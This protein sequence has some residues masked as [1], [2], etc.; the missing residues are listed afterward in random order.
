[1]KSLVFS[2]FEISHTDRERKTQVRYPYMPF[3]DME[4][5]IPGM[6]QPRC[7]YGEEGDIL[8]IKEAWRPSRMNH[9]LTDDFDPD[10]GPLSYVPKA[11]AHSQYEYFADVSPKYRHESGVWSS[12]ETMPTEAARFF[13]QIESVCLQNLHEISIADCLAEGIRV[14]TTSELPDPASL[15]LVKTL[16]KTYWEERYGEGSWLVNPVVWVITYRKVS[17]PP[18]RD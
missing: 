14:S 18:S 9:E 2:P 8:R 13:V 7:P 10:Y 6:V 15:N 17:K 4:A 3:L 5:F 1:M 11:S 16:Y 12:A